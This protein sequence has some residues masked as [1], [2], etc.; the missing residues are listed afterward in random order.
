ME[1]EGPDLSTH[2]K[3]QKHW[4]KYIKQDNDCQTQKRTVITEKQ[5]TNKVLPQLTALSFPDNGVGRGTQ[6]RPW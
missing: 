6:G 1:Q 4:T 2:Q 5:E 3:Q